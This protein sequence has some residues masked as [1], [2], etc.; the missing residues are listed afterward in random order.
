LAD[1]RGLESEGEGDMIGADAIIAIPV[2]RATSRSVIQ[3]QIIERDENIQELRD[4]VA[5]SQDQGAALAE[6]LSEQSLMTDID[7]W[8]KKPMR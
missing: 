6:F 7:R 4:L 5:R 2:T 1:S 8:M 3:E